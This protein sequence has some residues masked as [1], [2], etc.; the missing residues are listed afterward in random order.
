MRQ[1]FERRLGGKTPLDAR[2]E[3]SR[4]IVHMDSIIDLERAF[5]H[6]QHRKVYKDCT[7]SIDGRLYETLPAL[8]GKRATVLLDPHQPVKG[9]EVL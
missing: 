8:I 1:R 2:L 9:L 6:E 4:Y 5:L 7:L 3:K